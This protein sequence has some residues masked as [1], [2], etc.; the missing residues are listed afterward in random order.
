M[1]S[2]RL[3]AAREKRLIDINKMGAKMM[4]LA[5]STISSRT[6]TRPGLSRICLALLLLAGASILALDRPAAAADENAR[7]EALEKENANLREENAA[8]RER[9]RLQRENAALRE[10]LQRQP[11]SAAVAPPAAKSAAPVAAGTWTANP[12]LAGAMAA[13]YKAPP[14]AAPIFSWTGFYGGANVGYSFGTANDAFNAFVLEP[15]FPPCSPIA[16]GGSFCPAGGDSSAMKGAIGGLQ[17][18]YD[19]QF[20]RY[21]AGIETDIEISGQKGSDSLAL[22]FPNP[23]FVTPVVLAASNAENLEWLGTLRGRLGITSD[24]WLAYGT[25][26]LA[27]GEVK[28]NGSAAVTGAPVSGNIG[29]CVPAGCPFQPFAAWTNSQTRVGWTAGLGVERV[30]GNND[31]WSVKVEYLYVDLGRVSTNFATLPMRPGSLD[32]GVGGQTIAIG[33]GSGTISTHVTDNIVRVGA[34]YRF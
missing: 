5:H 27:Y 25:G 23:P 19:Y 16:G 15:V 4:A 7:L 24:R 3:T 10:H 21:L 30:I 12:A 8:L 28:L 14:A 33:P 34:N 13:A 1:P 2:S 11:S 31:H 22:G 26:G 32:V 9:V 20:G 17:A 29:S 6:V 18:G